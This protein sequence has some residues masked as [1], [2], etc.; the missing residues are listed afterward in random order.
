MTDKASP[1]GWVVQV[2]IPAPT[3]PSTQEG[4]RWKGPQMLGAPSFEYCN[5]AIAS[6]DKAV[7]A[8]RKY[9][10]GAK[11]DAGVVNACTVREL[12]PAE[13]AALGLKAGEVRP[14]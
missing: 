12:S 5:V 2:T 1:A 11:A 7:E 8:T 9:L 14:A 13:V 10:A 6:P 3:A 4:A